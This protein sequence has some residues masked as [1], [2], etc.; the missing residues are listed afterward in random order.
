MSE[1]KDYLDANPI[2]FTL[3][4]LFFGL[5]LLYGISY[6]VR[7][8]ILKGIS[9]QADRYRV[10]KIINFIGYFLFFIWALSLF[11]DKLDGSEIFIGAIGAGITI[12]LQEVIMSFAG[13]LSITFGKL[14]KVGDRVNIGGVQG[15]VISIGMMRTALME[16]GEWIHSDHYNGRIVYISNNM[17]FK[18]AVFN[19]SGDFPYIWDEID[20][21]IDFGSDYDLTQE[22]LLK[23][24]DEFTDSLSQEAGKTWSELSYN[25]YVENAN[26][27]PAISISISADYIVFKL[28]YIVDSRKR[29]LSKTKVS[30]AILHAIE[31]TEGKVRFAVNAVLMM[32][33]SSIAIKKE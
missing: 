17:I 18:Q 29:S 5:V 1:I 28:R 9:N 8:P 23:V 19:Y 4:E 21:P 2:V 26:M 12:A 16:I 10:G 22:L 13:W 27:E 15:D 3:L 32:D 24:A 25:F 6:V 30:K 7:K 14:Y 33:G 20:V 11:S 31:G